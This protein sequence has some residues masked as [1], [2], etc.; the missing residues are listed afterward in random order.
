MIAFK[1]QLLFRFEV[2]S[3]LSYAVKVQEDGGRRG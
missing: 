3:S 1:P 2:E